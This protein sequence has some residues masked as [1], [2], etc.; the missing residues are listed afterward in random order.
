MPLVLGIQEY[1][2]GRNVELFGEAWKNQRSGLSLSAKIYIQNV[3]PKF[4]GLFGKD[5]KPI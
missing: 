1:Y 2:F 3:I 4:E 5:I